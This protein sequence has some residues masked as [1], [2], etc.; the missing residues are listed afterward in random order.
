MS[1][2]IIIGAGAS[3]D[4]SHSKLPGAANFF[5]CIRRHPE[6]NNELQSRQLQDALTSLLPLSMSDLGSLRAL[7]KLNIEDLF[8]LASLEAEMDSN[9]KRVG[10]LTELIR[11]TIVTCSK[12]VKTG[13]NYSNFV[14]DILKEQT[15]VISFNWDTLLDEAL[16]DYF[17]PG[18]SIKKTPGLHWEFL[19]I[20]TAETSVN[21]FYSEDRPPPQKTFVAKPA[22]LKLHGSIDVVVCKNDQCRNYLLPFRVADCTGAHHC[23]DCYEKVAPFIVPPVQNKPIRQFHHIR[24]AWMLASKL[25]QQAEEV[26][27]W[28]YS[29]PVTDHW[30]R[31]LMGHVWSPEARCRKLI[32]INP[33]V[34]GFNNRNQADVLRK[35]FIGRFLPW[36][37]LLPGGIKVEAYKYYDLFVKGEQVTA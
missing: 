26:I 23:Q 1:R 14:R 31:W 15:S 18:T 13:G 3:I 11:K 28:G 16:P 12:E 9:D 36:S 7:D 17:A 10:H 37:S 35:K 22:Y 20:C 5:G 8:T 2:V 34:A 33:E 32:I 25:I 6:L 27:V 19:R 24:R 30:S 21:S 29:L 4:A